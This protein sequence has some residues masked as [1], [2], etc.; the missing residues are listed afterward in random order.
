MAHF[1]PIQDGGKQTLALQENDTAPESST[2]EGTVAI[3]EG[4]GGVPFGPIGVGRPLRVQ[5]Q[6]LYS[7]MVF[8]G[9]GLS[10]S[11]LVCTSAVKTLIQTSA[12]ARAV[13][14]FNPRVQSRTDLVFPAT[15]TGSTIA[16]YSKALTVPALTFTFEVS[17]NQVDTA[18]FNNFSSLLSSAAGLPIFAT[19]NAYLMAASAATKVAGNLADVIFN[20]QKVLQITDQVTFGLPPVSDTVAHQ[21]LFVDDHV[22]KDFAGEVNGKYQ[23]MPDGQLLSIKDN[24]PYRGK[25]PYLTVAYD[26]TPVPQ[27]E[28]FQALAASAD[29]I[30]SF[31]GDPNSTPGAALTSDLQTAVK[32]YN[33]F[34]YRAQAQ[35]IKNSAAGGNLN[36]DQQKVLTALVANIQ[37][38]AFKVGLP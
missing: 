23:L 18:A 35:Q 2:L 22:Q 29:L 3:P 14:I 11:S 16:Y 9:F 33:D 32:L 5:I 38:P 15:L 21:S 30:S 34:Q 19:A 27:L 25:Y 31:F 20:K 17:I 4:P 24:S 8:D 10:S 1:A 13:N 7:G 37:D 12:Q 6:H 28:D 36:P 26:G